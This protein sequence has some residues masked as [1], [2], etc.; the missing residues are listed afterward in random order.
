M[1]KVVIIFT[2]ILIS[3][4]SVGSF[5]IYTCYL[6]SYHRAYQSFAI[7]QSSNTN[8]TKIF[9][10]PSQLYSDSETITWEDG[11]NEINMDGIL[12]DIISISSEKGKVVL[13]VLSDYQ[14]TEMKK[15]FASTYDVNSSKSSSTPIKLLKQF[16]SLKFLNGNDF[17]L[18][19]FIS[20]GFQSL[21][22]KYKFNLTNVFLSL[23]TP[24][25]TTIN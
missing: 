6:H 19:E 22:N 15:E 3:V 8:I 7:Q 25:P 20:V 11:N 9:I 10:N 12:Y 4:F 18:N 17:S 2:S 16:L 5:L 24:P 1:K 21:Y 23:E 13:T 14:E